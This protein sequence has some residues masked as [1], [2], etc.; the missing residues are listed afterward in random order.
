MVCGSADA[1]QWGRKE[2][3]ADFYDV[4]GDIEALLAPRKPVFAAAQHPA[5]HPGRCAS[6]VLDGAAIGFVGEFHPKW[7][8]AY[9]LAQA[10]VMFELELDAVLQRGVPAFKSVS[11]FQ[12]VERDIA[13]MLPEAVG[14]ESLMQAIWAAPTM[15]LLRDAVLFDIYRP[16]VNQQTQGTAL[17]ASEKSMAVRLSLNSEVATLA[18]DQID[19]AVQAILASL[20]ESL[21]A[22]Q[23]A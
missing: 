3:G 10:P 19:A 14:H 22:R 7:R 8:Q 11:K 13:V 1:P 12:A 6:V 16:G 2:Q 15:G 5:M 9:D 20:K 4:K 21:G 17:A 23:R 18:D